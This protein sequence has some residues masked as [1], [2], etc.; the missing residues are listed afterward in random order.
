MIKMTYSHISY[1]YMR[2]VLCLYIKVNAQKSPMK[3]FMIWSL[4]CKI[5][6]CKTTKT[7]SELN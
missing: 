2:L 7:K 6:L 1:T 4:G 5:C 3:T